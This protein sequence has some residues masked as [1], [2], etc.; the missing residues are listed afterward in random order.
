MKKLFLFLCLA[1]LML[2][3][4]SQAQETTTV[5]DSRTRF[6]FGVKAGI[7]NANVWDEESQN[8]NANNKLGLVFGAFAGFPIGNLLG[9][10][11]EFLIAQKGFKG[12]GFLLGTEY[13]FSR[14][15][16]HVDIPLQLQ[17]KPSALLTLLIGPQISYLIHQKDVYTFGANS[18]ALSQEFDNEN[19]RKSTL[20]FTAGADVNFTKLVAS[21]RLG[22]DFQN[23]NGDGTSSTPRYKNQWLQLTLGYKI[24]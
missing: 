5:L 22:Y 4:P 2:G 3:N 16:T 13:S 7:N 20:G 18:T 19:L 9:F 12:S 23:N 10:Q 15:T 11:P 24:Y 6:T 1:F 17:V 21:V 14:T 8:F